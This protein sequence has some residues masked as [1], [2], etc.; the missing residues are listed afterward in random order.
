MVSEVKE[1][2]E[3]D[4]KRCVGEALPPGL[5]LIGCWISETANRCDRLPPLENTHLD[6]GGSQMKMAAWLYVL[7]IAK[8]PALTFPF[9]GWNH[10]YTCL[11]WRYFDV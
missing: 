5:K 4:E 3:S 6:A 2:H 1:L 7:Y 9:R 11:Q 10:G 8:T